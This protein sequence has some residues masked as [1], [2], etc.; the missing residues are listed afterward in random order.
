MVVLGLAFVAFAAGLGGEPRLVDVNRSESSLIVILLPESPEGA[1]PGKAHVVTAKDWRADACFDSSLPHKSWFHIVAESDSLRIDT[2]AAR[3][4]AGI[5]SEPAP[6]ESLRSLHERLFD[7]LWVREYRQIR[8]QSMSARLENG[9]LV[10][11]GWLTVRGKEAKLVVPVNVE[12]GG[13]GSLWFRG[14]VSVTLTSLGLDPAS[15]SA[16]PRLQD[17]VK[18]RFAILGRLTNRACP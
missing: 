9:V 15:L 17:A 6:E 8:F 12:N 5:E 3:K 14:E 7:A 2:P 16:D 1:P 18:I 10:F 13:G 4:A 11:D